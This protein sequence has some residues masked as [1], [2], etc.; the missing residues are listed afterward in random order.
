MHKFQ[1]RAPRF[2]VDLPV[3]FNIQN[4]TLTGRCREI[5]KEGMRL[6]LRHPLPSDACGT[7][8]LSYQDRVI[9]LGARV[10]YTGATHGGLVFLYESE[11]ERSA[12]AQLVGSLANTQ[13]RPGP[14]L[15]Y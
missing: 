3:R 9:E 13:S 10:A 14:V 4:S 15:L 11:R 12:V 6:E 2:A 5:S 1:Y 7:V 8:F